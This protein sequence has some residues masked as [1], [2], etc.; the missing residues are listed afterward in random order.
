MDLSTLLHISL[1]TPLVAAGII[2]LFLRRGGYL[3]AGVS[4]L[5]AAIILVCTGIILFTWDGQEAVVAS[6][7]WL[8]MGSFHVEIGYLFNHETALMLFVVAFVGFWIHLFSVGYMDD[9]DSKGR[10]FAGLSIFMFSMLGI[11]VANNLIMM[12]LFWELVGFSS[13]MLIA[14]YWDKGFAAEAA[15]KAFIVNRVGDFGFLLGI[16]WA[17]WHFGTTDLLLMAEQVEAEPA[18]LKTGMGLLL[19]CGFLGKSAQFPLHVWLTDAMAGPTPVSALIHAATMVAAGIYFMARI[20]FLLTPEVL[21]VVLWLSVAMVVLAGFWALGQ[22]DIK[23]TLAYSTLSHLGYMGAAIG[24][25]YPLLALMHMAMH[26]FFKATLF[27]CSGSV[28][29][30]CH[31]EQDMFRMGGLF[32]R[33][34]IT[35]LAFLVAALSIAAFPFTAGFYS[36]DTIISG[37]FAR[38]LEGAGQHYYVA[39]GLLLLGALATALYMGRML[40]VVFFGRPRSEHAEKARESSLFMTLPLIVL[41]IVLS[42][43]GGWF[44]YEWSW[45]DGRMDALLP[46][47]VVPAMLPDFTAIHAAVEAYHWPLLAAGFAAMFIGFIVTF[48]FYGRSAAGDRLQAG[49][50]LVYHVLAKHGWFDDLYD[51]YVAKVQQRFVDLLGFLDLIL[52]SGLAV[53]GT[54]GVVG[55][56]GIFTRSLHTG[57]LHGYV[58]WFLGGLAIFA[59]FA[60]GLLK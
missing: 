60:L 28:I 16:V 44:V 21:D 7:T 49:S 38:G 2:A 12:F 3:A 57:S 4:V 58:Y 22:N 24:L 46:A 14:H 50:P 20:F 26:A 59:A 13:Y 11:V 41:G 52:I 1:L 53:R 54:A 18:L 32:K 34:P 27:L 19:M 33:M 29:H 5:A 56:L 45:L 42:L 51:W 55:L 35:G 10:F 37:A 6:M 8:S 43:G 47:V 40:W 36:K 9:D 31:H 48:F 23:K 25:G 30:A 39:Y 17:Y 15:K